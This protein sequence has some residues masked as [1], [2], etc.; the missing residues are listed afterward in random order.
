MIDVT[1]TAPYANVEN[2]TQA[3]V[4]DLRENATQPIA[5]LTVETEATE[6]AFATWRADLQIAPKPG[7]PF[8]DGM[9]VLVNGVDAAV[10][11]NADG[12]VTASVLFEDPSY[13][14][15]VYEDTDYG[16]VFDADYYRVHYP[17]AVAES[18][19][20]SQALLAWYV[21][22]G[23]ALGQQANAF[24]DP[25]EALATVPDIADLYGDSAEGAIWY[26]LESGYEDL[27]T[28]MDHLFTPQV[29]AAQ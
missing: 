18:G 17:D 1:L 10:T 25:A 29:R 7:V 20:D 5:T 26:F 19:E 22:N 6:D 8:A 3:T 4:D 13:R 2:R 11:A 14:P 28:T 12:S 24:F 15:A 21:E 23:I 27:M 9:R 16:L